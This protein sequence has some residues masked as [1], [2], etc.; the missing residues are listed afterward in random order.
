MRRAANATRPDRHRLSP[1]DRRFRAAFEACHITPAE[2][3]HRSHIRLAYAYLVDAGPAGAARLL[4]AG[5][6][7]FLQHHRLD[8]GKFHETLTRA[9][10]A[11][12]W[13]FMRRTPP[14]PSA[15][16]FIERNPALLDA[17]IMLTHYSSDLLF[18]PAARARFVAPDRATFPGH[19]AA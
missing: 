9:W 17:R 2:F 11:A 12:V 10:T 8:T 16:V 3:D 1:D 18:S 7:T 13:H 5:L 14:C 19:E 6:L 4:R 15:E